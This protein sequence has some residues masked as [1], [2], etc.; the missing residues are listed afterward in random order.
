M[1]AASYTAAA[2]HPVQVHLVLSS[3][4]RVHPAARREHGTRS[5][6]VVGGTRITRG[7]EV[8][9]SSFLLPRCRDQILGAV[10]RNPPLKGTH[11][12]SQCSWLEAG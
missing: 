7:D 6:R 5:L 3:R 8:R 9:G 4:S 10:T 1:I 12:P 2:V 11:P